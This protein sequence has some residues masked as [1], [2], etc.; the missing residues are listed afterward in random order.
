MSDLTPRDDSEE[1]EDEQSR[2]TRYYWDFIE[3]NS[4]ILEA[5]EEN[6]S[7]TFTFPMPGRYHPFLTVVNNYNKVGIKNKAV[8]VKMPDIRPHEIVL[9]YFRHG[10]ESPQ[11][12]AATLGTVSVT[13]SKSDID[14]R[15]YG[16]S[17]PSTMAQ[18]NYTFSVPSLNYSSTVEVLAAL[19]ITDASTYVNG[20]LNNLETHINNVFD[21][22]EQTSFRQWGSGIIQHIKTEFSRL[23]EADK[24]QM[25]L[26]LKTNMEGVDLQEL[27]SG[28][29][30]GSQGSGEDFGQN[31]LGKLNINKGLLAFAAGLAIIGR[32]ILLAPEPT[33]TTKLIGVVFITSAAVLV[34]FA[35]KRFIIKSI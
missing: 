31:E 23:N 4:E 11:Q 28:S 32:V 35:K 13:L 33:N 10:K 7:T 17:V 2:L 27:L 26:L 8:E 22:D 29:A 19:T 1:N 3:G 9:F 34:G 5:S 6:N 16:F 24:Q 20:E 18:G 30:S 12:I 25:A 14:P 21:G 15:V